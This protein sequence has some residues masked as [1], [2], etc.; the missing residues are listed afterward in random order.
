MEPA[1]LKING[2][3]V[4]FPVTV[5]TE[6]EVGFDILKLRSSTKAI[7]LDPGFAN[8]GSCESS[9]TYID[10][11]KGILR[12]RGYSIED[13]ATNSTFIEVA[14]LLI[15][16]HLPTKE[17]LHKFNEDLTHH[18]LLHEDMKKFFEGYPASA[19]P[20]SVLSTIVSSKPPAPPIW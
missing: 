6:Q 2:Q 20:M 14:Y 12:Y 16:G 3:E 5:G 19:P 4:D 18:S 17:E 13:L 15:N 7:T 9:I 11:E 8:T 1:H 10:G